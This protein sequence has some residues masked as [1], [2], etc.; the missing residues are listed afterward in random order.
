MRHR[1]AHR[2]LGRT[3]PHRIALLRNLATSLFDTERIRT[4]LPNGYAVAVPAYL[5]YTTCSE[6][7][8]SK[9][10]HLQACWEIGSVSAQ[11]MRGGPKAWWP[12]TATR[13]PLVGCSSNGTGGSIPSLSIALRTW[14]PA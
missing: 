10:A 8:A 14:S 6:G 11:A 4:T 3:T 12:M 7:G 13:R 5:H 9:I 1:V 2:K